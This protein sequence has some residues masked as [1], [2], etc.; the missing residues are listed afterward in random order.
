MGTY[1]RDIHRKIVERAATRASERR[2]RPWLLLSHTV[3]GLRRRLALVPAGERAA[4][5]FAIVLMAALVP[6][7]LALLK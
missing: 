4:V 5:L 6:V 2:R 7:T 3:H 1:T